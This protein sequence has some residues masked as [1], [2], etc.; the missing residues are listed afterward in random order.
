M[1]L[2]KSIYQ[3]PEQKEGSSCNFYFARNEEFQFFLTKTVLDRT[4]NAIF[5]IKKVDLDESLLNR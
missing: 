1:S 3:N 5:N 2:S 4:S